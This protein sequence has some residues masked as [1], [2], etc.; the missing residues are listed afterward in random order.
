MKTRKLETLLAVVS[1]AFLLS[2]CSET[3]NNVDDT[4][5]SSRTEKS[6]EL[7]TE[8]RI[9]CDFTAELNE[10]EIAGLMEMREEEKLAHDVY[11]YYYDLFQH[12][13]FKNIS[14][15]EAQHT[16]AVLQ[17]INGYGLE[18]PALPEAGEFRAQKFIDLYDALT[19][20]ER[21]TEA[22]KVGALIEE[23]DIADLKIHIDETEVT[24]IKTV[25]G[26]LLSASKIHLKA[27]SRILAQ[28]GESYTPAVLSGEEYQEIIENTS[29]IVE[30]ETSTWPG[31]CDGTGPNA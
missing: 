5:A 2:A 19:N 8:P 10:A 14:D 7:A 17:L 24:T 30:G 15:S 27:F 20:A 22:L 28:M 18:D 12:I 3:M 29:T 11:V 26:N 1:I 21:L 4:I 25:Y 23:T 13:V 31:V 9:N 16:S 6:S